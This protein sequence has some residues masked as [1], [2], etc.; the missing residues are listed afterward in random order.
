MDVEHA[1]RVTTITRL[2]RYAEKTKSQMV[3]I[4]PIA[5]ELAKLALYLCNF[6][7]FLDTS[8]VFTQNP[9]E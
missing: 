7:T 3:S 4:V 1:Y 5:L 9:T 8:Q 2:M 6:T